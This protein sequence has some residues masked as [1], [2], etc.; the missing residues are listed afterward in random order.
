M[1]KAIFP[2]EL[3]CNE[4]NEINKTLLNDYKKETNF[5]RGY[6]QKLEKFFKFIGYQNLPFNSF[7]KAN[8]ERYIEVMVDNNFSEDTINTLFGALSGYKNFHIKKNP[9][10]F[11]KDFLFDLPINFFKNVKP[12]DAFA[13]NQIQLNLIREYNRQKFQ[14]EY[15]FEIF[16]QLG[17]K[18]KDLAICKPENHDRQSFC[19]RTANGKEIRYNIHIADILE[20]VPEDQELK[21][22]EMV[23]NYYLIKVTEFFRQQ[24]PPVY[25]KERPISY[26]D[27]I[28]SHK[29]YILNCPFCGQFNENV[30]KN[31]VLIKTEQNA[32][33]RLVCSQCKGVSNG[34]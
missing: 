29:K 32:G 6:Y 13:F 1:P 9:S 17:I 34:N 8:V 18:K 25:F 12:S 5:S 31:W 26:S 22:T 14:N 19:F 3:L 24:T 10:L 15:I 21:L 33:Y 27:I 7:T 4:I 16:F 11:R 20:R 28:K 30:A 23:T 2:K